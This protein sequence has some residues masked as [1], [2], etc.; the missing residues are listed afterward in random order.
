MGRI[1]LTWIHRN[2][3]T[4]TDINRGQETVRKAAHLSPDGQ[5][6]KAGTQSEAGPGVGVGVGGTPAGRTG[7]AAG[8][9]N[10]APIYGSTKVVPSVEQLL[11]CPRK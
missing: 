3:A 7:Q 2:T 8:R 10:G 1:V 5:G 11:P 6:W 9:F 4:R